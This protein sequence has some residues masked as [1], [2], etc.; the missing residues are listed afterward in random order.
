MKKGCRAEGSADEVDKCSQLRAL[1]LCPPGGCDPGHRAHT[2]AEN[3]VF[4]R[5]DGKMADLDKA[6]PTDGTTENAK[7]RRQRWEFSETT[8]NA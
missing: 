8:K 5:S 6:G 4:L 3:A 7:I 2:V 1:R